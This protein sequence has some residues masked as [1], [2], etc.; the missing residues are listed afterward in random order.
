MKYYSRTPQE[1]RNYLDKK[2]ETCKNARRRSYTLQIV[3][4]VM[5]TIIIAVFG[6]KIKQLKFM[7]NTDNDLPV[8]TSLTTITWKGYSFDSKCQK[9]SCTIKAIGHDSTAA[10]LIGIKI[11]DAEKRIIYEEHKV[12]LQNNDKQRFIFGLPFEITKDYKISIVLLN[13]DLFE[14]ASFQIYP[15]NEP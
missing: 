7:T 5:L 1:L 3:N 6:T 15:E 8:S 9:N 12:L 4:M 14:V 11:L 2:G 10:D 13:N